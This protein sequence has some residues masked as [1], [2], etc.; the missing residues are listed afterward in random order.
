M[1]KTIE[2]NNMLLEMPEP[3]NKLVGANL[4]EFVIEAEVKDLTDKRVRNTITRGNQTWIRAAYFKSAF[5]FEDFKE[6]FELY[7]DNVVT[8][9]ELYFFIGRQIY[10]YNHD[11]T[12]YPSRAK[13]RWFTHGGK[14]DWHQ[15]K[16][17]I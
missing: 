4:D 8:L 17:P 13:Q 3:F 10:S 1:N 7:K 2:L 5:L 12:A 15:C 16:C 6:L 14:K 9:A 11:N